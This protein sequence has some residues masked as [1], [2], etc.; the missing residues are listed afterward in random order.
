MLL[1]LILSTAYDLT[2]RGKNREFSSLS[3]IY[4]DNLMF[5]HPFSGDQKPLFSVFSV[6]TNGRNLFETN[7]TSSDNI[8]N[9]LDGIRALSIM[10]VVHGN[11]VQTYVDFPLINKKQFREVRK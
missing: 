1:L 2:M 11:R 10:W 7:Q 8:I 9:C 5:T 3:R 4:F 6:Y